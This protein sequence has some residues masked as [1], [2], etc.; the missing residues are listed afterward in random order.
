MNQDAF[1]EALRS[2]D[3]EF[4]N[5]AKD[6]HP[7][8][9]NTGRWHHLAEAACFIVIVLAFWSLASWKSGAESW[10][11][12]V[13]SPDYELNK[14]FTRI[15]NF[16]DISVLNKLEDPVPVTDLYVLGLKTDSSFFDFI[17]RYADAEIENYTNLGLD[18]SQVDFSAGAFVPFLDEAQIG[19]T[20]NTAPDA[21]SDFE[22]NFTNPEE[23]SNTFF[24]ICFPKIIDGKLSAVFLISCDE[25]GRPVYSDYFNIDGSEWFSGGGDRDAVYRKR[26]FQWLSLAAYTSE[27]QP[28]FCLEYH[29]NQNDDIYN[30]I[31][32][33]VYCSG[34][35]DQELA[36]WINEALTRMNAE[37]NK[38]IQLEIE[39]V[40]WSL[41]GE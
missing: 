16:Q 35:F 23:G 3:E 21:S 12:F 33:T 1:F 5:Q 19:L 41:G 29:Q 27:D 13:S 7:R 17:M 2:I 6:Y 38:Y 39:V 25:N 26:I 34:G 37:L 20:N 8:Q 15:N 14:Y 36:S 22:D 28:L 30:L 9:T 10:V 32:D 40:N 31:G 18:L 24:S 4:I 11:N